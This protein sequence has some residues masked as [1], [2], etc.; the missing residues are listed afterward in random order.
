MSALIYAMDAVLYYTTGMLDRGDE[1]IMVETAACKVFCSE[2]GWQVVNDAMQI[3]GGESYMTENEVERIFRDSR[4]NTIVEGANEVMQSFIFA[5]GAKQLAEQMLGVQ[6][7]LD[8]KEFS[9]NFVRAAIPL[10]LEVFGKIRKPAPEITKLHGSLHGPAD[11]VRRLISELT[12][13]F[14]YASNVH[15][16]AIVTRQVVQARLADAAIYI[17]AWLCTLGRLDMDIRAGED[18]TEMARNKAAAE[19][20]FDLAELEIK[21]RFAA[22]RENADK[23]ML[24]AAEAALAHAETMPNSDYSIPER[25]PNAMGTGRELKQDGIKQFPGTG[26]AVAGGTGR[27]H[28]EETIE[29]L[30]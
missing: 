21:K 4:I 11:R 29:G 17:H 12:F 18:G 27:E 20:F 6:E 15:K 28:M 9:L 14:K 7:A 30:H 2:F 10:G 22:L 24:A 26:G 19:H 1:D 8:N 5:Y 3:L 13:Q 16:D 23:S 25:S